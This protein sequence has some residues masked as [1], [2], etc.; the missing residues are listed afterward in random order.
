[1]VIV[2][3]IL[4]HMTRSAPCPRRIGPLLISTLLTLSAPALGATFESWLADL[5]GEARALG[6]RE[7]VL[8]EALADLVPDTRVTERDRHQPEFTQ[9]L[10][11]YLAARVTDARVRE[12]RAMLSTHRHVVESIESTY[13]VA[14][15]VVLAI[16]G[17]ES[18]YGRHT[19]GFPVVRSLATLAW[20]ERR[21]AFFRRELLAAL[22]ILDAGD[23]KLSEFKGSWAGALGQPQLLPS[24]YLRHAQ[25]VDGDGRR[26]IWTS[27]PDVLG[28][29]AQALEDNGWRPGIPWGVEAEVNREREPLP[30]RDAQGC[31]AWLRHEGPLPLSEWLRRGVEVTTDAIAPDELATLLSLEGHHYLVTGSFGALLGYNCSNAYALAVALLADRIVAP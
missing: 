20:D 2:L 4:W 7:S 16:W 29:I 13:G 25:D 14:G 28:S 3:P 23:V 19:G 27:V 15:P 6:I 17:M 30:V 22:R 1:V 10:D 31:R 26:D 11:A 5:R 9:T 12:G 8:A 21:P 18:G 24:A